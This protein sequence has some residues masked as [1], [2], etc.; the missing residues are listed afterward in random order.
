MMKMMN[1]NR[2]RSSSSSHPLL[3]LTC[4]DERNNI[5][6]SKQGRVNILRC[7]SQILMCHCM[8]KHCKNDPIHTNDVW[9]QQLEVH[10]CEPE[11]SCNELQLDHNKCIKL[12]EV[13][14]WLLIMLIILGVSIALVILILICMIGYKKLKAFRLRRSKKSGSQSHIRMTIASSPNV[15]SQVVYMETGQP[16]SSQCEQPSGCSSWNRQKNSTASNFNKPSNNMTKFS[17]QQH[18]HRNTNYGQKFSKDIIKPT[19]SFL[20]RAVS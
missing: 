13:N 6:A 15:A 19:R 9:C 5:I 1:N 20:Q 10:P 3:N 4:N 17:H 8:N 18:Q 14:R 16:Q 11:P 2:L 12:P 7:C